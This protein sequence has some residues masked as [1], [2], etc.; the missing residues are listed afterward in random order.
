MVGGKAG[1]GKGREGNE[2]WM[3][4]GLGVLKMGELRRERRRGPW[5]FRYPG[6]SIWRGQQGK[7][8]GSRGEENRG[9]K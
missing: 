6:Y 5:L 2:R 4:R 7:G 8:A 3:D 9:E 1:E